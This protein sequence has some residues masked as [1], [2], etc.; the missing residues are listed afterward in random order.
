M[1]R[2]K[3][4][5]TSS[6][7]LAGVLFEQTR[8][9]LSRRGDPK[10]TLRQ[11]R[12]TCTSVCHSS[13]STFRPRPSASTKKSN[14]SSRTSSGSMSIESPG[15][16]RIESTTVVAECCAKDVPRH[17]LVGSC[18]SNDVGEFLASMSLL[19]GNL[20]IDGPGREGNDGRRRCNAVPW[21][22][23]TTVG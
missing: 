6:V 12:H 3:G 14:I 16:H 15:L 9:R 19:N 17:R 7:S 13:K 2:G 23:V 8:H 22:M 5:Q 10:T 4:G 18:Q 21:S 1:T 11:R 20:L